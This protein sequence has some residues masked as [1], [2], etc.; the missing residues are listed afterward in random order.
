MNKLE[1]Q[2]KEFLDE[3]KEKVYKAQYQAL[4]AVNKELINLYWEIGKSILEKQQRYKWGKSVVENLSKDLQNEFPGVKG[5]S[6]DNL[7]RMRKFAMHYN[8]NE[9]L[10]PLV[11]E[12]GWSHNII[13]M[14]KCKEDLEREFYIK[15]TRKYGWTK[16]VLINQIEAKAYERF[17]INQTSFDKTLAKKYKHQAKLAVK[18]S[19]SFDFLEMNEVYSEREIELGLIKNI[20]KFLLEMG[21]DFAFMGNQY[22]VQVGNEDFYIDML[23][24]HRRL[25]SLVVVELKAASFK[26][27]YAGK[28][29]FY[30]T[31]L[32]E[33]IK[34]ED[35]NPAIGIIICKDKDRTI[36]EYALKDMNSPMGVSTYTL[37]EEL[38]Q[39][40]KNLLP[41]PEEIAK[42]LEGFMED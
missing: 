36:V 1:K 2:Y 11:Q 19:Y 22:R 13:V 10:A 18:D 28:M 9:K 14:E 17:L 15:M 7:W 41:S 30:L 31:T 33:T 34:T 35:E 8:N 37:K 21:G 24:Y 25:K 12:I 16:N 26:P 5:F 40:M 3:I 6:S 42:S 32:N 4:K 39:E 23:L 38:P 20:R 27:E 29:Q